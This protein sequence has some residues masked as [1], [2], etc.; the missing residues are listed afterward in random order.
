MQA[1]QPMDRPLRAPLDEVQPPDLSPLLH[2]DH[3]L[4]LAQSLDQTRVRDQPDNLR[5]NA[6]WPTIQPAQMD[7]YSDGPH[8]LLAMDANALENACIAPGCA[9]ALRDKSASA[10]RADAEP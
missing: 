6:K 7:R 3:P 8:T 4:L 10:Q 1:S 2:A 9:T 5:L